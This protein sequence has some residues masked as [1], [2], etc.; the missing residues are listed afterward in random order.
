MGLSQ[1]EVAY[2]LGAESGAKVCRY[3]QLVRDPSFQTAL[4]FE[5]VFLKPVSELFPKLYQKIAKDVAEHAKVL[6][7]KTERQAPFHQH[8]RKALNDIITKQVK[9]SKRRA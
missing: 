9:G 7:R 8:K 6:L 3:E 1:E 2:L 4:A 5:A